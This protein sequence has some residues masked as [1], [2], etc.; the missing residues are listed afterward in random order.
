[1][2]I[3]L[4][5]ASL[6]VGAIGMTWAALDKRIGAE[7]ERIMI[8]PEG[9]KLCPIF[10]QTDN[11]FEGKAERAFEH[12]PLYTTIN[13]RAVVPTLFSFGAVSIY[14]RSQPLYFSPLTEESERWL[15]S[16]NDYD[17]IWSYGDGEELKQILRSKSTMIY[18][19]D[20]FTLWRVNR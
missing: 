20:G 14:F 17:Y 7:V 8:L 10:I 9:A 15:E 3:W 19:A 12:L 6:R 16:L 18:E 13:R 1:M 11:V 2:F 5:T 4:I